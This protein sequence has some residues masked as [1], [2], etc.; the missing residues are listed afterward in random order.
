MLLGIRMSLYHTHF[1]CP[2][3]ISSRKCQRGVVDLV[4]MIKEPELA[5]SHSGLRLQE[6]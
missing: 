3:K 4:W 2:R 6:K 5:C 1:P